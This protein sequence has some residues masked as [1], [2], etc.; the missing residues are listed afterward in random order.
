MVN[1]ACDS[2]TTCECARLATTRAHVSTDGRW[3]ASVVADFT[4]C[5]F[6]DAPLFRNDHK[7]R[8]TAPFC[9]NGYKLGWISFQLMRVFF[10][11]SGR[12]CCEASGC[13]DIANIL[14]CKS[15]V[16][17]N[18][19]ALRS[20]IFSN[21]IHSLLAPPSVQTISLLEPAHVDPFFSRS[22]HFLLTALEWLDAIEH[23]LPAYL[24]VHICA[25]SYDIKLKQSVQ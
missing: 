23:I 20:N 12:R 24:I 8:W 17:Q 19:S 3:Q 21:S 10:L 9:S 14:W 13:G 2:E 18:R 15:I 11:P 4:R 7:Y 5:F 16:S 6:V 22:L 1:T 25:H